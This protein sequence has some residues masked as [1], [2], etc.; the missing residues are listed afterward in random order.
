MQPNTYQKRYLLRRIAV[1]ALPV[2]SIAAVA[3]AGSVILQGSHAQD[4]TS[5]QA[6]ASTAHFSTT[7]DSPCCHLSVRNVT[8]TVGE[9]KR[10]SMTLTVNNA[11]KSV[12]LLS[13]GLQLT[14][15]DTL[16]QSYPYTAKYLAPGAVVGGPVAAGATT[17]EQLD[18]DIAP[19]TVPHILSFQVDGSAQPVILGVEL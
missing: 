1:M 19:N 17:T 15:F 2:L 4:I 13:P 18:F 7:A 9:F 11:T 5:S 3:F 10:V 8:A 14:L 16:G 12:L 6:G